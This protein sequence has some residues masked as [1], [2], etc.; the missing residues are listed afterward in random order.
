[1]FAAAPKSNALYVAM[2]DVARDIREREAPP[3]PLHLRNAPTALMKGFGYGRE[4]QYDQDS[5][6]RVSGQEF[7]PESLQG[8]T[9]YRPGEYGFEREMAKRMAWWEKLRRKARGGG[10]NDGGEG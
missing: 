3:V 4:Y 8:R 5:P 9:Y 2:S 7:L 6:G 1:M 10:E